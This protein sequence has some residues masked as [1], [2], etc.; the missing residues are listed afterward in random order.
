MKQK[1]RDRAT[2]VMLIGSITFVLVVFF[3]W[4]L[5]LAL[6][7]YFDADEYAYLHWAYNV[8]SGKLPY[9]DFFFY[10]PPGF[11]WVLAPL[12]AFFHGVTAFIAGRVLAFVIFCA[13]SLV[14]GLL[15]WEVRRSWVA[16][17]APLLLV[18]LPL[19]SDKFLEIRPDTLAMLLAT[20]GLT[21]QVRGIRGKKIAV[22]FFSGVFYGLSLLV[23][24]K[25]LPQVAVA[26][27]VAI[28]W[29]I[30]VPRSGISLREKKKG[31]NILPFFIGILVPIG[32]LGL[33][34]LFLRDIG[35]VWY[36]ITSLPAVVG[37][38]TA[39]M[40]PMQPD[41]FFY[42]N[43]TY[44]GETGWSAGLFVNHV[45]WIIGLTMG[46]VRLLT[47]W[48]G[49]SV[50]PQG[51]AMAGKGESWSEFL[52]AGSFFA[53]VIF[54][55]WIYPLRHAQYLIPIAVFVSF[56][57]AD[58]VDIVWAKAKRNS[59]SFIMG[60]TSIIILLGTLYKTFL[61]VNSP[62]LVWT[63]KAALA[64]IENIHKTIPFDQYLLD[65]DGRTLYYKDPYY[66]C[67]LPFG[68]FVPFM[69][70]KPSSVISYLEKTQTLYIYE[71]DLLRVNTLSIDEK[72]YIRAHFVPDPNI[73][74]LLER[75]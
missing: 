56:Y 74:G 64:N 8:F 41:L 29:G 40:F 14:T 48:L 45:V 72:N 71:G 27:L 18:F 52:I 38:E 53:H 17:L 7:R 4:K 13:L 49:P 31:K 23:L 59:I 69:K 32:M 25:T 42:P 19:P 75:M 5:Q 57:A 61:L 60:I 62:K 36:S 21:F 28:G 1:R 24:P 3:W 30:W 51:A 26:V 73:A 33:W 47:P 6:T 70:P 58:A 54:F 66:I 16:L 15:F 9:R 44:Y 34:S 2:L 63:N 68:E 12:F 67:C 46:A 39:K 65:L 37:Q 50:A 20:L 22:W 10:V 35:L 11:L 55:F 43:D